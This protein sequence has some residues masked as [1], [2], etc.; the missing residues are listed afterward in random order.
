M[1][2]ISINL[3]RVDLHYFFLFSSYFARILSWYFGGDF[4]CLNMYVRN[5]IKC[6]LPNHCASPLDLMLSTI[7]EIPNPKVHHWA[8]NMPHLHDTKELNLEKHH[9][10][11]NPI[12]C[13]KLCRHLSQHL[14]PFKQQRQRL[15]LDSN[16]RAWV[17]VSSLHLL[18]ILLQ[19]RRIGFL[20]SLSKP[21]LLSVTRFP[22]SPY[23]NYFS[24]W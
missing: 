7:I 16:I 11:W 21:H 15:M 23:S 12:P 14:S 19:M 24:H 20:L 2:A 9:T 10:K 13:Q 3:T 17:Q 6:H 1:N 18:Q 22:G 4:Y 8:K 5:Y